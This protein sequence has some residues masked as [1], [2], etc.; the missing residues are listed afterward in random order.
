MKKV[1]VGYIYTPDGYCFVNIDSWG[2]YVPAYQTCLLKRKKDAGKFA[3][4]KVRMTIEE[5]N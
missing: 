4:K 2:G 5:I 3:V 1:L